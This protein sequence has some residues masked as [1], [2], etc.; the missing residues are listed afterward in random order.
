MEEI[1]IEVTVAIVNRFD[2]V[3]VTIVIVPPPLRGR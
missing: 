2:K 1:S 3:D